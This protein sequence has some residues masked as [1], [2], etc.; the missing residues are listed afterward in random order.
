MKKIKSLFAALI[1][2]FGMLTTLADGIGIYINNIAADTDRVMKNAGWKYEVSDP[3]P[4]DQLF[5]R[6]ERERTITIIRNGTYLIS[7]SNTTDHVRLAV[8][9]DCE[10]YLENLVLETNPMVVTYTKGIDEYGY[11]RIYHAITIGAKR[12]VKI[13][14]SGTRVEVCGS[15]S[16]GDEVDIDGKLG[17]LVS[18]GAKVSFSKATGTDVHFNS[19]INMGTAVFS[20]S[21]SDTGSMIVYNTGSLEYRGTGATQFLGAFRYALL[22]GASK[23]AVYVTDGYRYKYDDFKLSDLCQPKLPDTAETFEMAED[24]G[25]LLIENGTHRISSCKKID[26][27]GGVV[28]GLGLSCESLYVAGTGRVDYEAGIVASKA[29]TVVGGELRSS[30]GYVKSDD[31]IITG[32]VVY[33]N[34]GLVGGL[35]R[36]SGGEVTAFGFRGVRGMDY[37]D[38]CYYL[39]INPEASET[40]RL[41]RTRAAI[42]GEKVVISGGRVYANYGDP[43]LFEHVKGVLY[44]QS[45]IAWSPNWQVIG[46]AGIGGT[47]CPV[48]ISGGEIYANGGGSSDYSAFGHAYSGA[49]I[50]GDW[51]GLPGEIT[52]TGGELHVNGG[53]YSCAIGPGSGVDTSA[54]Q[55][56]I[57]GGTVTANGGH[58]CPAIFSNERYPTLIKGATVIANRGAY[59]THA[60][61]DISDSHNLAAVISEGSVLFCGCSG[62]KVFDLQGR[63]LHRVVLVG[64]SSAWADSLV[65][66]SGLPYAYKN[67]HFNNNH[68]MCLW[69]PD[70]SYSFTVNEYQYTV[71]VNGADTTAVREGLVKVKVTIDANG[72]EFS[73][74]SKTKVYE[75]DYGSPF[76]I[77]DEEKIEYPTREGYTIESWDCG[78]IDSL[79]EDRYVTTYWKEKPAAS[80]GTKEEGK[81]QKCSWLFIA[82]TDVSGGGVFPNGETE[83]ELWLPVGSKIDLSEIPVPTPVNADYRFYGWWDNEAAKWLEDGDTVDFGHNVFATFIE[84]DISY[85]TFYLCK[86]AVA[87]TQADFEQGGTYNVQRYWDITQYLSPGKWAGHRFVGWF[88]QPGGKGEQFHYDDWDGTRYGRQLTDDDLA[89][90]AYWELEAAEWTMNRY[91][92]AT[93]AELGV[94]VPDLSTVK[95]VKL[96]N[97]PKGVKLVQDKAKTTWY[98]EGVPTETRGIGSNAVAV[99]FQFKEKGKADSLQTLTLNV[100]PDVH[101]EAQFDKNSIVSVAASDLFHESVDATWKMSGMAANIKYATKDNT[102]W[103][104]GDKTEHVESALTFYGQPNKLVAMTILGKKPVKSQVP[105]LTT[106][107]TEVYSAEVLICP[108][109][110]DYNATYTVYAN[111]D[112]D[113]IELAGVFYGPT[114]PKTTATPMPSG[115]KFTSKEITNNKIYGTIPAGSLYGKPTKIGIFAVTFKNGNNNDLGYVLIRVADPAAPEVGAYFGTKK[116]K[117]K[118][119]IAKGTEGAEQNKPIALMVGATVSIPLAVSEGAS[120]KASNLPAGLKLVQDKK[121]KLWTIQGVPSKAGTFLAKVTATRNKVA[122]AVAYI[123][124]VEPNAFAGAW[125]GCVESL[126]YGSVRTPAL[127]S[128]NVAAGGATKVVVTERGKPTY[129]YSAKSFAWDELNGNASLSFEIPLTKGQAKQGYWFT[130]RFTIELVDRGDGFLVASGAVGYT[131]PGGYELNLEDHF[132]A[133]PVVPAAVLNEHGVFGRYSDACPTTWVFA[134]DL[135]EDGAPPAPLAVVSASP[136]M[137]TRGKAKGSS[138]VQVKFADGTV[139]KLAKVEVVRV[140]ADLDDQKSYA[141]APFAA[142]G[143]KAAGSRVY[144]FDALTANSSDAFTDFAF[145]AAG[146]V[147]YETGDGG[148]RAMD[149]WAAA[150]NRFNHDF[151]ADVM[152]Q[153][154]G[155]EAR[156]LCDF[157]AEGVE[158][159]TLVRGDSTDRKTGDYDKVLVYDLAGEL[160]TTVN[161][162]FVKETGLATVKFTSKDKVH[163]YTVDLL[164]DEGDFTMAGVVT[165]S[166][167]DG[168]VKK[169]ATG[170]VDVYGM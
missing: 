115:M 46:T 105:G 119:A 31:I 16:G 61:T 79:K 113:L 43:T 52:I 123:F 167:K 9:A 130:R 6:K 160:L 7:G 39:I 57:L 165:D 71:T 141:Y 35:V 147:R 78:S 81:V 82:D 40:E 121:T 112:M 75:I 28:S 72:G 47:G 106:S 24:K 3:I 125:R 70:G 13:H 146:T 2:S 118:K 45:R 58:D 85:V 17:I 74:G 151:L 143:A 41:E 18:S 126:Q 34:T 64:G 38:N 84:N 153:W 51:M 117:L 63:R 93:L 109:Y 131:A 132:Q 149:V 104:D 56:S 170:L 166:W 19:L 91:C 95:S 129:T 138:K 110:R 94:A 66:I 11:M 26:V 68:Q 49:A 116:T 142:T 135:G 88:S 89:F 50:G 29:L 80:K 168:K 102:K 10:L 145:L 54:K 60:A 73:D 42:G 134:E 163:T 53:Y 44:S 1:A 96:E 159:F 25:E 8:D 77:F 161:A 65:E 111:V 128:V 36:I 158:T 21:W 157:G 23:K 139:A 108:Q 33:A 14:A 100:V 101:V 97:P 92:C 90:Y 164:F 120:V 99:R 150:P 155:Q 127:V 5:M 136:D 4:C 114:E 15:G 122:T 98:V 87:E 140:G 86:T 48:T 32:G 27:S 22:Y 144:V 169:T 12:N 59:D 148:V 30:R 156:M 69:L 20:S 162:K 76:S 67:A 154:I 137:K 103:K 124:E 107:F 62:Q 37:S 152:N 133:W 55:I 83:L